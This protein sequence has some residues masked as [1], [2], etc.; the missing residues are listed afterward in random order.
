[1]KRGFSL[2]EVLL[3]V[4]LM[5]LIA[6]MSIP[7]SANLLARNNLDVAATTIA[8]GLRRAQVLSEAVQGD[9]TWGLGV[10]GG[11]ITVFKG[12]TYAGRDATYDESSELPP[13]IT[14]SGLTSVV[15]SH[16]QGLPDTVGTFTLTSYT[17]ETRTITINAKGTLTY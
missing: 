6:V 4:A 3:S 12:A 16:R 9:S 8:Q 2:I 5:A 17:N 13:S 10:Q 7:L 11:N 14:P 1:M 15:F